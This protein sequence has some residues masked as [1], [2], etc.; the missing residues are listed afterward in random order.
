MSLPCIFLW[1]VRWLPCYG[2]LLLGLELNFGMCHLCIKKLVWWEMTY[3]RAV[4]N[5]LLRGFITIEYIWEMLNKVKFQGFYWNVHHCVKGLCN[6]IHSYLSNPIFWHGPL[7]LIR[8]CVPMRVSC[9]NFRWRLPPDVLWMEVT[10]LNLC[11]LGGVVRSW[12]VLFCSRSRTWSL[13]CCRGLAHQDEWLP[14]YHIVWM[15]GFSWSF[16]GEYST[17]WK[18]SLYLLLICYLIYVIIMV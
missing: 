15:F 14:C 7:H 6:R 17:M 4:S 3:P 5:C 2:F 9:R 1:S 12:M 18:S 8:I 10:N 16:C 13:H 11:L